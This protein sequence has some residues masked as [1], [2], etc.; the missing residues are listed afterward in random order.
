M[1]SPVAAR[2][3]TPSALS[4][5]THIVSK[6]LCLIIQWKGLAVTNPGYIVFIIYANRVDEL[7]EYE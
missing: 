1:F 7:L 2:G 6:A 4:S 3:P 5:K